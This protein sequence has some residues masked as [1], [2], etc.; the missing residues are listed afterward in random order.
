LVVVARIAAAV[1]ARDAAAA[2]ATGLASRARAARRAALPGRS[3]LRLLYVRRRRRRL[4]ERRAH[5]LPRPAGVVRSVEAGLRRP[6]VDE[7]VD[8]RGLRLRIDAERDAPHVAFRQSLRQ[9]RPSR[10]RVGR[11][12]NLALGSAAD[13]LSDT[14]APLPR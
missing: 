12:V 5:A 3:L 11:L 10:T 9:L 1:H 6:R 7:R 4:A 2:S 13:H 8:A 14:A